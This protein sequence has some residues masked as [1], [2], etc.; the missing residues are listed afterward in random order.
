M[1]VHVEGCARNG[2]AIFAHILRDQSEKAFSGQRTYENAA[3]L[4]FDSMVFWYHYINVFGNSLGFIHVPFA[5]YLGIV[6]SESGFSSLNS[7]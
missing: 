4:Y 7:F 3:W 5:L 1:N 2:K 6:A